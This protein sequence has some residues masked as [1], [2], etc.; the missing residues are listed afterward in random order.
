M[1]AFDLVGLRLVLNREEKRSR[2]QLEKFLHPALNFLR[3]S[4]RA[5]KRRAVSLGKAKRL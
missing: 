4:R 5:N 3:N 1:E 2:E